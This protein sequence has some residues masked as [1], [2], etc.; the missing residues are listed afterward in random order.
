VDLLIDFKVYTVG[1]DY[2]VR[3]SDIRITRF[4]RKA[5]WLGSMYPCIPILTSTYNL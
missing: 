5:M 1:G 3:V 4:T 2:T